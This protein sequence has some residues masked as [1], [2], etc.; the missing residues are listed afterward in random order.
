[1]IM[2]PQH[3]KA[4][5]PGSRQSETQTSL[6]RYR[7]ELE[8]LNFTGSNF[9]HDTFQKVN[10]NGAD[11]I[12]WMRRLVCAFVVLKPTKTVFFVLRSIYKTPL[13]CQP[14]LT[15]MSCFVYKVI[16]DL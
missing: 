15:V 10:N 6:L 9:R 1:M 8:N 13:S 2:V 12:V 4:C 16:R 7:D 14:L 11:K 5:L 3:D